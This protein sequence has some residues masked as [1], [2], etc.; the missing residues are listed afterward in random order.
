PSAP[1]CL[2]CHAWG[3]FP[4]FYRFLNS[5][6]PSL[7]LGRTSEAGGQKSTIRGKRW[8]ACCEMIQ[9]MRLNEKVLRKVRKVRNKQENPGISRGSSCALVAHVRNKY[10]SGA[11]I[12][13]R[14]GS[15]AQPSSRPVIGGSADNRTSGKC[16]LDIRPMSF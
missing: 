11:V 2:I 13:G 4:G 6:C 3:D 7:G 14:C 1:N 12:L 9:E 8:K 5:A 16:T 10:L 15:R